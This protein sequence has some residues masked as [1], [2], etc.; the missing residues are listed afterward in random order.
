MSGTT[1][2]RNAP[3]ELTADGRR[4]G[5]DPARA[6]PAPEGLEDDTGRVGRTPPADVA[7]RR[8]APRTAEAVLAVLELRLGMGE[9]CGVNCNE[10]T[11]W[12]GLDAAWCAMAVSF[13]LVHGG[14]EDG[15]RI[16]LPGVVTTTTLG[17]SWV[18]DIIDDFSR[19]GRWDGSPRPGDVF[20]IREG[21]HTGLV[22]EVGGDTITT[23]EGNWDDSLVSI[24]RAIADCD[25]FGHPP[26]ADGD[27][28]GGGDGG[29]GEAPPPWP[30]RYL[31][32][33]T[34]IMQDHDVWTWQAQMA[35]RGWA[36]GVDGWFGPESDG[37]CRAFQ[38][39]QGL[40]VDGWVGPDT[41]AA[42]W[43]PRR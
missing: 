11:R 13:A 42:A 14:F 43:R 41:W 8:L 1:T 27:G 4:L 30:G 2:P 26:Y 6:T 20:T 22:R 23:L 16:D 5:R 15:G 39:D 32:L 33:T 35:V 17:W 36:I 19:A 24:E 3:P 28:R 12:W 25:G 18:P 37:V 9:E 21:S 29:G 34:P 7:A 31:H 38:E 40:G 10:I